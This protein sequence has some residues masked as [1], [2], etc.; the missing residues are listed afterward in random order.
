MTLGD[1]GWMAKRLTPVRGEPY[2]RFPAA[3]NWK[4]G[5]KYVSDSD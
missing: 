2:T 3:G 5:I 1:W 4:M